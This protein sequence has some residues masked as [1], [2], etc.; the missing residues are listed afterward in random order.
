VDAEEARV[1]GL[2]SRVVDDPAAVAAEIAANDPHA[3]AVVRDCLRDDRQVAERERAE[4]A[5]FAR[6]IDRHGDSL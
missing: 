2:V 4:R 5:A 1:I 6:L 3:L